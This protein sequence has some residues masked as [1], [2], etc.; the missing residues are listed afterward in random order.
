MTRVIGRIG[1]IGKRFKTFSPKNI[2]P[3][4]NIIYHI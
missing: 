3:K 4:F 1:R 2:N